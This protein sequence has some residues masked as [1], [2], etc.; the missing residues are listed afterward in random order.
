MD[1]IGLDAAIVR[2]SHGRLPD[3]PEEGPVAIS[4]E[5]SLARPA[6]AM[7]DVFDL[8]LDHLGR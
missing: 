6:F 3:R 5:K 8:V 7:T 1:V 4:S 2:G